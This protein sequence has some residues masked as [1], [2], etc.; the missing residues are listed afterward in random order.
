MP[1]YCE[2]AEPGRPRCHE[3][4]SHVCDHCGKVICRGHCRLA[5]EPRERDATFGLCRRPAAA[6][7]DLC[8]ACRELERWAGRAIDEVAADA[9]EEFFAGPGR[10]FVGPASRGRPA[11]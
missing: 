5:R 4:V 8:T 1:R 2:Q 10:H 9:A 7:L 6:A 11:R 3:P